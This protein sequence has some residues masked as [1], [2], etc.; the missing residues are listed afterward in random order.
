MDP[1]EPPAAP[2]S[3]PTL[4]EE[5]VENDLMFGDE[6]DEDVEL[7]FGGEYSDRKD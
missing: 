2:P 7:G 4:P 3:P 5:S 6:E 1:V